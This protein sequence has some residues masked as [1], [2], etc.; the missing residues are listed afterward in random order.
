MGEF[1]WVLVQYGF[2][3]PRGYTKSEPGAVATGS[4]RMLNRF[5]FSNKA[6]FCIDPR[7]RASRDDPVA[8]APGSDFVYP[9]G[10]PLQGRLH[11]T[12]FINFLSLMSADELPIII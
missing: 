12:T 9:P 11:F 3:V 5:V 2:E 10:R 1:G 6:R 8:T 4:K 7:G